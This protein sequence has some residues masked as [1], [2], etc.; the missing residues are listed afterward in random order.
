MVGYVDDEIFDKSENTFLIRDP[1]LSIP[2]LYRILND[3]A[4]AEAGFEQQLELFE[5]IKRKLGRSP[6]VIDG[7]ALRR[8]PAGVVTAYF[9]ALGLD[10]MLSA[11]NWQQGGRVDW[12]GR[13]EWHRAAHKSTGFVPNIGRIDLDPY[14]LRVRKTIERCLPIYEYLLSFSVHRSCP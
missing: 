10:P 13:E 3:Y 14:P 2:S 1:R 6:V 11:L 7:E 9:E 4:E 12:A 5:K 8:D